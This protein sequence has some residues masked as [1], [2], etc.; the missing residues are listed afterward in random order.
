MPLEINEVFYNL[1]KH[2]VGADMVPTICACCETKVTDLSTDPCH[3]HICSDCYE[4]SGMKQTMKCA[5]CEQPF[6]QM[7]NLDLT[8]NLDINYETSFDIAYSCVHVN[9]FEYRVNEEITVLDFD[10]DPSVRCAPGIHYCLKLS[11]IFIYFEFMN[12]P[13]GT[14]VSD[15]PWSEEEQIAPAIPIDTNFDLQIDPDLQML[16]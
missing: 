1:D 13:S 9:G 3:H 7:I 16:E 15:L 5:T 11:D 10:P 6:D 8:R 14:Y 12:I 2:Y 4:G